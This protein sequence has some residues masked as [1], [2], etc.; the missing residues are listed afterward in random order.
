[1]KT[2]LWSLLILAIWTR[3]ANACEDTVPGAL[4]PAPHGGIVEPMRTSSDEELEPAIEVENLNP[5]LSKLGVD[6]NLQVKDDVFFEGTY[7]NKQLKLYPLAINPPKT[8]IFTSLSPKR[9]F[10]EVSAKIE[11]PWKNKTFPIVLE[12]TD[13]ALIAEVD[14]ENIHRFIIYLSAT[15]LGKQ[16]KVKIQLE[17]E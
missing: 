13:E 8:A 12:S 14:A 11:F 6:K 3:T 1:M 5:I 2:L 15:H 17:N 16:K 7:R 9:D 4:P 10:S